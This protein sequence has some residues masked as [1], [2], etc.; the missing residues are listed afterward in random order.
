MNGV[1][2]LI[3][4]IEIKSSLSFD[5]LLSITFLSFDLLLSIT[6][7]YLSLITF[8]LKIASSSMRSVKINK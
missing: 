2:S 3:L 4:I 5:L 6:F 8:Y 1:F 7:L